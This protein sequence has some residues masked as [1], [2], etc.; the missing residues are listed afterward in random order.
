MGYLHTIKSVVMLIYAYTHIN[1]ISAETQF[2]MMKWLA[3]S[4]QENVA[5]KW[6]APVTTTPLSPT[7]REVSEWH[8]EHS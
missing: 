2:E 8:P 3:F 4:I 1:V 6:K 7:H 5:L